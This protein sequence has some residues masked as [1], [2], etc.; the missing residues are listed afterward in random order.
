MDAVR[1]THPGVATG[2]LLEGGVSLEDAIEWATRL[3]HVAVIPEW[4]MLIG[5]DGVSLVKSAHEAGVGVATWTV[6]DVQ[7]ALQLARIG[8]DAI[9][10]NDPGLMVAAIERSTQE[11][12]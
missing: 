8:V 3:G 7:V 5:P 2:L 12:S 4:P 9:I 10:T 6:N 1:S 11:D